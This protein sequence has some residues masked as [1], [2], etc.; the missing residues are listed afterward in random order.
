MFNLNNSTWECMCQSHINMWVKPKTKCGDHELKVEVNAWINCQQ[1]SIHFGLWHQGTS[2]EWE[3]RT[4]VHQ[5]GNRWRT[6]WEWR[7]ASLVQLS[8]ATGGSPWMVSSNV[9]NRRSSQVPAFAS[10]T[11]LPRRVILII[12]LLFIPGKQKTKQKKNHN[13]KQNWKPK[14]LI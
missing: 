12:R 2:E 8:P 7:E 13:K 1:K 14:K 3:R 9:V 11:C 10:A 5:T 6:G 4:S